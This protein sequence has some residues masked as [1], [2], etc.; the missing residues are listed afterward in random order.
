MAYTAYGVPLFLNAAFVPT[1]DS[2]NWENLYCGYRY[3]P[4]TG[5]FHVRYR[6][7]HPVLGCWVQ[8]DPYAYAGGTSI[9]EYVQSQAISFID[10]SGLQGHLPGGRPSQPPPSQ[11]AICDIPALCHNWPNPVP[12]PDPECLSACV[13]LC[14]GGNGSSRRGCENS[15]QSKCRE[16][17]RRI[18][19]HKPCDFNF[20]LELKGIL[21]ELKKRL[22]DCCKA[23]AA[24]N[25]ACYSYADDCFKGHNLSGPKYTLETAG[26]TLWWGLGAVV[27][28]GVIITDSDGKN[29][30]VHANPRGLGLCP[31]FQVDCYPETW[32]FPKI[33]G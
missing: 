26:G 30:Y 21:S 17:S 16:E 31:T 5:L 22:S 18:G 9:Y 1:S 14:S 15:C 13:P 32:I 7:L 12:S 8:R 25:N 33:K 10:P 28:M 27:V 24:N 4:A 20:N 11:G 3:E 29:L 2:Y 6:V 19:R 23:G